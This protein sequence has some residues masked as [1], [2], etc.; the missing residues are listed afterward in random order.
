MIRDTATMNTPTTQLTLLRFGH[1]CKP[2]KIIGAS[3]Y[4]IPWTRMLAHEDWKLYVVVA[5]T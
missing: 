3:R 5:T 1:R 2:I 4:M